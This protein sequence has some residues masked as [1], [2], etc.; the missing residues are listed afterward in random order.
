QRDEAVG[1]DVVGNLVAIAGGC[2]GEVAVQLV[3]RGKAHRVHDTV[4]T[5]GP[6]LAQLGEHLL[7][8][9]I[10]G[11]VTGEAHVRTGTPV[12]GETFDAALEL[13]VLV[14]EGQ[15][16]TFAVHGRGNTRRDG[17]FAGNTNDEYAFSA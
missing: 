7:D 9:G 1:A 4:D 8:L 12:A 3:A 15:L 13:V 14:G 17:Q 6:F 10:I 11:H 2:F 5:I 16:S